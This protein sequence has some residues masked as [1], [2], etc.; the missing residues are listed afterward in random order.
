LE[1]LK[2][3]GRSVGANFPVEVRHRVTLFLEEF[4]NDKNLPPTLPEREADALVAAKVEEI[5][6]QLQAKEAQEVREAAD[7]EKT[8]RLLEIG[9]STATTLTLSWDQRDAVDARAEVTRQLKACVDAGWNAEE[10][11]RRV[12]GII[13]EWEEVADEDGDRPAYREGDGGYEEDEE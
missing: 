12:E 13:G 6:K 1:D 4:V 3:F 2:A 9:R 10:V 8:Q 11:R 5:R 7:R